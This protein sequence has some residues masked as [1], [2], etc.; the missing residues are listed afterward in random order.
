MG[1]RL[2]EDLHV[3]VESPPVVGELSAAPLPRLQPHG[4]PHHVQEGEHDETHVLEGLVAPP[5][6]HLLREER[7]GRVREGARGG[8]ERVAKGE[9][10]GWGG[11]SRC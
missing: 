11:E 8:E 1:S 5:E 4:R 7:G 9:E 2:G 6:E 10:R 3:G